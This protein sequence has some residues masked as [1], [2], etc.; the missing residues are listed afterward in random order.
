M[1][2]NGASKENT[3]AIVGGGIGGLGLAIGLLNKN[4]PFHI[5]EGTVQSINH[6]YLFA[7]IIYRNISWQRILLPPLSSTSQPDWRVDPDIPRKPP[8]PSP[9]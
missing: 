3:V 1:A 5:Y 2:T 9:K 6:S 4:V 7:L 8:Q